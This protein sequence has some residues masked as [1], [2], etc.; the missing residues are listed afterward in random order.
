M[1]DFRVDGYAVDRGDEI[2][3]VEALDFVAD[4]QRRFGARRD[5]LPR[6]RVAPRDEIARIGRLD[7]AD[8]AGPGGRLDRGRRAR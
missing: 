2:L 4:L 6:R 5:D 1:T 3:T 8:T 7:F